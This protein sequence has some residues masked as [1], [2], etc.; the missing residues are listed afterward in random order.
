MAQS[1]NFRFYKQTVP[2]VSELK[3]CAGEDEGCEMFGMPK[4]KME[5][6]PSHLAGRMKGRSLTC[7]TWRRRR[8]RRCRRGEEGLFWCAEGENKS[9]WE[10]SVL[11]RPKSRYWYWF[12]FTQVKVKQLKIHKCVWEGFLFTVCFKLLLHRSKN[13]SFSRLTTKTLLKCNNFLFFFKIKEDY[14]SEGKSIE[15]WMKMKRDKAR[16]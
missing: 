2:A 12:C 15:W 6:L 4:G 1:S 9:A 11:Y 8:R 16:K 10:E 3:R 5:G 14:W 7:R 13:E